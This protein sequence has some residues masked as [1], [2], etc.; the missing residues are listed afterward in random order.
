MRDDKP[1]ARGAVAGAVFLAPL[2]V[3]SAAGYAIG[4]LFGAA[5]PLGIAGFFG[6]LV[7][8]F[9]LVYARFRDI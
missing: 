9:A 6:G 3:L 5:V 7:A 2:I 8:G 4:S 1:L